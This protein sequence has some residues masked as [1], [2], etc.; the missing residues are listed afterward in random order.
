MRKTTKSNGTEADRIQQLLT[1]LY[2]GNQSKMA[3]DI[4]IA[5][6]VISR[7]VTGKHQ[8]GK[9][10]L[11]AIAAHP[12]VNPGWLATGLGDPLLSAVRPETTSGWPV[13]IARCLLPGLPVE[14]HHLLTPEVHYVPGVTYRDTIYAIRARDCM[15]DQLAQLHRILAADLL[16]VDA[17]ATAWKKSINVL[18][19]KLCAIR[20]AAGDMHSIQFHQVFVNE[21]GNGI[22]YETDDQIQKRLGQIADSREVR[23]QYGKEQRSILLDGD[24]SENPKQIETLKAND[25]LGIAIE[26]RRIF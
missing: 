20:T 14:H 6:P 5:Q 10:L 7:V 16:L 9:R 26:L 12:K 13:P 24:G 8:P 19:G 21:R 15:T 17:D 18:E 2:D 22:F 25:L 23:K 3:E 11:S 1:L 4:G